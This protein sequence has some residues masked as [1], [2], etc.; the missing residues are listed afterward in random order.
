MRAHVAKIPLEIYERNP[1]T[2]FPANNCCA[3]EYTARIYFV[4]LCQIMHA[5]SLASK[6]MGLPSFFARLDRDACARAIDKCI[7]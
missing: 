3:R 4:T 1:F 5:C 7:S 6:V 2:N